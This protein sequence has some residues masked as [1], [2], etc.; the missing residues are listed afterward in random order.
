MATIT[1]PAV[2]STAKPVIDWAGIVAVAVGA[3]GLTLATSWGG[4]TYPWI[5]V[6]IIGLV[7][8]SMTAFAVFVL[9]E[10]RA[11][12][13]ILPL[14]L[15]SSRVFS[16]CCALA[17]VV[18]FAML[19]SITF[20]P[21]LLQYVDGVSATASGVRMLPLVL[22]LLVTSVG[23]GTIV[24]RT[25]RYKIFPLAG[26]LIMALGLYLMSRIDATTSTLL[27]SVYMVVLGAGIGLC[28]QVLTLIVQNTARYE[29][30][31]VSTSG[32]T[33]FRTLGSSFGAAVFGSLFANFLTARLPEA[34]RASP[35]VDPRVV[36]TPEAL[37]A[38]PAAHIMPIINAYA[39]SLDKVFLWSVPVALVGFLLALA[40]KEVPLRSSARA[41]AADMGDGFGMPRRESNER[42]LERAIGAIMTTRVRDHAPRIIERSGTTLPTASAWG[43]IEITRFAR[44]RGDA[45]IDEIARWHRLPT[46]VLDPTFDRLV[47][48]GMIHR[49][50]GI[51]ALT[52]AGESEVSTLIAALRARLREQ[53]ADWGAQPDDGEINRVLDR[54]ARRMLGDEADA[55][56]PALA[57]A[58]SGA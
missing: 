13:P 29:D 53:L 46:A 6:E 45:H 38:L 18:G 25:G 47:A 40:L 34:I 21:T 30:L 14:R 41:S 23:A 11:V 31:G 32:V 2:R 44:A 24:G 12:E 10:N 42:C 52:P 17:F 56:R 33:F 55:E 49:T 36:S 3:G 16:V 5:S 26:T 1:I 37:H 43:V 28:M 8:V 19:G 7:V 20:L 22:G 50:D 54:I 4:T 57:A 48:D 9:V 27:E 58:A 15:F 39:D 51:L 35:G